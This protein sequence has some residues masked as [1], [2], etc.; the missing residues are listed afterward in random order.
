MGDP[1][2]HRL[3][4]S[5]QARTAHDIMWEEARSLR[6]HLAGVFVERDAARMDAERERTHG[7]QRV[8]DLR[9]AQDQQLTQLRDE[10][11]ELR[12]DQLAP[13]SCSPVSRCRELR[14]S[15]SRVNHPSL[16]AAC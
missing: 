13:V 5:E 1:W 8:G 6:E 2:H 16:K 3:G 10:L 7:E 11:A 14:A 4:P 15:T 12:Q 9:T